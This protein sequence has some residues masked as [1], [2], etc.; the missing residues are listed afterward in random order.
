[1]KTIDL[2]VRGMDCASCAAHVRDALEGVEGVES[3]DVLV[4]AEK[5]IVTYDEARADL[6]RL[7]DAVAAAGY[8]VPADAL[9]GSDGA[10]GLAAR[11]AGAQAFG[12]GALGVTGLA[13]G[14]VLLVVVAGEWL[15]LFEAATHRIPFAVGVVI[16][17]LVG[18][19]AFVGVVRAALRR[20]VIS[21]TLMMVGVLAALVVGQWVTAA[22][23]A[24]FM[25]VGD[26]V[27]GFTLGKG[28]RALRDLAALAPATAR[29]ERGGRAEEVPV[30]EVRAGDVVVVRP[31]ERIPVDGVVVDG[32]ASIEQAAITGEAMPVDAGP[33]TEVFAATIVRGGALRVRTR[34]V[35]S[36]ATFGRILRMVED[37]EANRGRVQSFADRFSGWYLPVVGGIALLTFLIR[38]DPLATAAVLVVACSCAFAIATPVAMLATIGAA[39]RRGLLIKGGAAIEALARADVILVDKTGTFTIGRPGVHDVISLDGSGPD[40]VLR[41]AASAERDSEHPLAAAIRGEASRRGI[42]LES[43]LEF[44]SLEGSGVVATVAGAAVVVGSARALGLDTL[45]PEAAHL[46]EEGATTAFVSR[47]GE[48]V[49]VIGLRDE[50]RPEVPAAVAALREMGFDSIELLTGDNEAAAAPVARALGI[51]F[52]AGL[53]PEDKIQVVEAHRAKGRTVVMIGDGVNDAPALARADV[54]IAMGA[55]GSDL[56]LEVA[57]VA[58]MRDDWSLVPDAFRTARRTMRVVKGNFG[59]TGIYNVVGLALAAVGILPP[60]LAAAAQSV[61]DLGI[62]GNSA[63]L[64]RSR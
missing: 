28:R 54:G 11:Q 57:H 9:P 39:A 50:V 32:G 45:P 49:G 47:G 24:F 61:P 25:R 7:A 30:A 36:D 29:V 33:G 43:P 6:A 2:P 44:R 17:A 51:S 40:E 58:L 26:F 63:R 48:L 31:G 60:I 3:A 41:L 14:A 8:S 16:V 1:M 15:G 62:L 4:A 35:G 13:F 53:L 27:E 5:A 56:A 46:A 12:R 52:R 37:A 19:P 42:A 10:A 23:V 38:R 34:R 22:V 55:A 59:L 64:L 20:R 18:W 21:H